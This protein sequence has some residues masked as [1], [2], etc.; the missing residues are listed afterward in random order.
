MH[1]A[2]STAL[3]ES[4]GPFVISTFELSD[5]CCTTNPLASPSKRAT[6][7]K[8]GEHG[9]VAVITHARPSTLDSRLR[10]GAAT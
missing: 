6:A 3:G 2:T 5:P 8:S 9:A 10:K 7:K 4:L 1:S